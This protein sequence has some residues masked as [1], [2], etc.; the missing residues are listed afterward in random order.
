MSR[1]RAQIFT[2]V[3]V[4]ATML[5]FQSAVFS[6]TESFAHP[7]WMVR[8]DVRAEVEN[9]TGYC[10]NQIGSRLGP[11]CN[12]T[13]DMR[14]RMEVMAL[15]ERGQAIAHAHDQTLKILQTVNPCSAWFNEVEPNAAEIFSSLH[16]ELVKGG[17]AETYSKPDDFGVPLLKDP[18]GAQAIGGAGSNASIWINSNGPFFVRGTRVVK[19]DSAGEV[20][21]YDGWHIMRL[22][23]YV[24]G[25]PEARVTIMLH[26]LGHIVGRLPNDDN[27][28]NGQS[29]RNTSE[30]LRHCR[31]EIH[32]LGLQDSRR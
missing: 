1:A 3:F 14:V 16:Y 20:S 8:A 29:S 18:W 6:Q 10:S 19:L 30:V 24:G 32:R 27:S 7:F 13:R 4:F 23:S 15:G 22:G 26:E 21:S 5:S 12:E 28:W 9:G 25:S 31:T 2:G 17:R 11:D